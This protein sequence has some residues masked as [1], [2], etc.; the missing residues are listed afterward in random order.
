MVC[1]KE[2]AGLTTPMLKCAAG[3]AI[4][5]GPIAAAGGLIAA[6]TQKW[7]NFKRMKILNNKLLEI[8]SSCI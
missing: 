4:M 3:E 6:Q 8:F 5:A 1:R 7:V 2:A